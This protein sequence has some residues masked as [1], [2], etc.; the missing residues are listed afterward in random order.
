M[1][2]A[3]IAWATDSENFRYASM[4]EAIES[5]DTDHDEGLTVWFGEV[6]DIKPSDIISTVNIIDNM[7]SSICDQV[8]EAAE[9]W[10][11]DIT[12]EQEASLQAI[13]EKWVA[14]NCPLHFWKIINVKEQF[15][16][17]A[18]VKE[19]LGEE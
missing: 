16:S 2:N 6:V 18:E 15:V 11:S 17:C 5:I 13:I 9:D 10:G 8:G 4:E 14:D 7:Q 1:S 12:P 19:I 3:K